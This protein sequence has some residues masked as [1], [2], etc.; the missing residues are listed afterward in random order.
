VGNVKLE[1][2]IDDRILRKILGGQKQQTKRE[3]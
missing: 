1:E 3:Y 2:L